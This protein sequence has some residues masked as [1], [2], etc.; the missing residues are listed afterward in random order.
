MFIAQR[1]AISVGD[2]Q[3][4]HADFFIVHVVAQAAQ[5]G[6]LGRDKDQVGAAVKPQRV[7]GDH[8]SDNGH[9]GWTI[10]AERLERQRIG[11]RM[12]GDDQV[13]GV[14]ADKGFGGQ[15]RIRPHGGRDGARAGA[16]VSGIEGGAPQAW[17]LDHFGIPVR[18]LVER[19][20]RVILEEVHHLGSDGLAILQAEGF[21]DGFS[22]GAMSAARVGEQEKDVRFFMGWVCHQCVGSG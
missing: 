21:D 13:G 20:G 10:L 18:H 4:H 14:R 3:S 12:V 15:A 7:R 16:A 11:K 9:E 19:Q 17:G 22:S 1:R 5:T 6:G 8:V 2:G